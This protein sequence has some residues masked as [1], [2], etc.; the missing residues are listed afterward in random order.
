M[1]SAR[2]TARSRVGAVHKSG[3]RTI[4]LPAL[5]AL[6]VVA[7]AA[8]GVVAG[9]EASTRRAPAAAD[10]AFGPL[11]ARAAA[12][13]SLVGRGY[14]AG[15]TSKG[16]PVL[17]RVSR[18]ARR[19]TRAVAGIEYNCSAGGTFAIPDGWNGLPIRRGRF[20][21]AVRRSF[22][23]KGLLVDESGTI[24]GRLNRSRTR[25]DGSWRTVRLERTATGAIVDVCDSG[26]L[27]FTARR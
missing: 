17:L 20:R 1:R 16:W 10:A 23:D 22:M 27:R 2:G 9:A 12:R 3:V 11:E 5:L 19:L 6:V 7:A 4:A 18:D 8:V 24:A 26:T 15:L 14:F 21:G 25:I 13:G